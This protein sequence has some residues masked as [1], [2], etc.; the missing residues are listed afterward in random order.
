MKLTMMRRLLLVLALATSVAA[1]VRIAPFRIG[2]TDLN[3][4]SVG[5][6]ARDDGFGAITLRH[7]PFSRQPSTL[8]YTPADV[9]GQLIPSAAIDLVA[10]P[11]LQS[12]R[13]APAGRGALLTWTIDDALYVASLSSDLRVGSPLRL[14]PTTG[15]QLACNDSRCLV[16]WSDA[17]TGQTKG[18]MTDLSGNELLR[19]DL[20][21][22]PS[23][24]VTDPAG[25]LLVGYDGVSRIDATG[26]VTFSVPLPP[27][28]YAV[29]GGDFDGAEYVLVL[30]VNDALFGNT[31]LIATLG[32]QGRFSTPVP[33]DLPRSDRALLL[34][35][36]QEHF[37]VLNAVI[38]TFGTPFVPGAGSIVPSASP[39]NVFV[40]RLS[41]ALDFLSRPI[42]ITSGVEPKLILDVVWNGVF[43]DLAYDDGV[44][45]YYANGETHFPINVA[46]LA[47]LSPQ[48]G[49][50]SDQSVSIGPLSQKS[51][52][53]ATNGNLRLAVWLEHGASEQTTLLRAERITSDGVRLDDTPIALDVAPD[54]V[55][56]RKAVAAIGG[57]FLVVFSEN[58]RPAAM[59]V[60]A[61]GRHERV[62]LPYVAGSVP[63]V[64]SNGRSW[65]IASGQSLG[66]GV[67]RV[68]Q[69]GGVLTPSVE[70]IGPANLFDLASDGDHF[71][72]LGSLLGSAICSSCL[73][74]DLQIFDADFTRVDKRVV[75]GDIGTSP[76]ITGNASGYVILSRTDAIVGRRLSRD[77]DLLSPPVRL[78]I[79]GSALDILPYAG[80][81]MTH[82]FNA[83][84]DDLVHLDRDTLAVTG[85]IV[86]PSAVQAVS[87]NDDGGV[88]VL[89]AKVLAENSLGIGVAQVL[90]EIAP[91]NP[92]RHISR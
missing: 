75:F 44:S 60:H 38:N 46:R 53:L 81:W 54:I 31:N 59:L 36:G 9:S 55:F 64:V 73:Q 45:S 14:G 37:L 80:G 21:S 29:I 16:T 66:I 13:V 39:S 91:G 7:S 19:I 61:D 5:V 88:S 76:L 51:P 22:S 18:L 82:V 15:S 30:L 71:A 8:R 65:L 43:Y 11:N 85:T 68:S 26:A 25:F 40:A 83:G 41:P 50:V 77:G 4:V 23:Q 78:P 20:R 32:L 92:R 17:F 6:L 87:A 90:Q 10:A 57:D 70:N 42:Q 63:Q 28:T 72:V 24:I 2:V 62:A 1:D 47:L 48:S 27:R 74:T 12:A 86:E 84:E 3:E 89:L 56:S 69:S 35:N 67:V 33:L 58:Q 52:V 79:R 49:I 34:W